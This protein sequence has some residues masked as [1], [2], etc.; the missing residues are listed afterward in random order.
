VRGKAHAAGALRYLAAIADNKATIAAAG[1]I[2]LLIAL[3]RR[4][5]EEGK[6]DFAG[7]L[8]NLAAIADNKATIA[9]AGAIPPLIALLRDGTS[10]GKSDAAGALGNRADNAANQIAIKSEGYETLVDAAANGP[11]EVAA[12]CLEILTLLDR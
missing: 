5:T 8:G 4:E 1:A 10:E 7:A 2:Q 3:L 6:A 9:A 12:L 11:A